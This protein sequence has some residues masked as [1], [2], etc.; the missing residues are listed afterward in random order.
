MVSLNRL[1][2]HIYAFLNRYF[3][4]PCPLCGRGFGG[5]E[6]GAGTLWYGSDLGVTVCP[7]CTVDG[8]LEMMQTNQIDRTKRLRESSHYMN[9]NDYQH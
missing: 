6:E 3:W 8:T 4:M 2:H 7:R 1:Y 5:H 9:N